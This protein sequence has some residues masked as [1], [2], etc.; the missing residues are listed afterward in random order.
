MLIFSISFSNLIK[1]PYFMER[2]FRGW[3]EA[4]RQGDFTN[5]FCIYTYTPPKHLSTRVFD[6]YLY[7]PRV[8]ASVKIYIY[9]LQQDKYKC[10]K[11]EWF[12]HTLDLHTVC[13]YKAIDTYTCNTGQNHNPPG[14]FVICLSV[15]WRWS[16]VSSFSAQFS[17]GNK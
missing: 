7:W 9:T 13:I 17:G 4:Q 11:F 16:S 3:K 1:F 5:N 6:K 2:T 10:K 14:V 15:D 8:N 12:T